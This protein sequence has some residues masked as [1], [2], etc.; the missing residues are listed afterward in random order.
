MER[1]S[2]HPH[3]P[4][5]ETLYLHVESEAACDAEYMY[6]YDSPPVEYIEYITSSSST[7]QKWQELPNPKHWEDSTFQPT[8]CGGNTLNLSSAQRR[9]FSWNSDAPEWVLVLGVELNIQTFWCLLVVLSN[10]INRRS[11]RELSN[12]MLYLAVFDFTSSKMF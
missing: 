6:M 8:F 7:E 3:V 10:K 9:Q 4:E 1:T 2:L 11:T 12:S 5:M